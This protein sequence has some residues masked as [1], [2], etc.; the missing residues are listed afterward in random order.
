MI[1]IV[2][3]CFILVF[4]LFEVSYALITVPEK[5]VMRNLKISRLFSVKIDNLFE[6]GEDRVWAAMRADA[7]TGNYA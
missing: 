5:I 6:G 2:L 7:K 4:G 1:S 3:F